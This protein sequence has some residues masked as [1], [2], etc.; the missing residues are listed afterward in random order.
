LR[1]ARDFG[2]DTVRTSHNS[3]NVAM[4]AIDT[5]LGYVRTPGTSVMEKALDNV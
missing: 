3:E 5:K 2:V 4:I 1:K